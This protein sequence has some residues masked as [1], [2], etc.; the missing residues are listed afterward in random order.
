MSLFPIRVKSK[1]RPP[2]TQATVTQPCFGTCEDDLSYVFKFDTPQFPMVRATEYVCSSIA[3]AVGLPVPHW[4]I[5]EDLDGTHVFASQVFG[6]KS[7]TAR[8]VQ[9][10]LNFLSKGIPN[11]EM[12]SQISRIYAFDLFIANDDRHI[13]NLIFRDHDGEKVVLAID[14]SHSLFGKWPLERNLPGPSS[15]TVK[16]GRMIRSHWGFNVIEAK[17][18]LERIRGIPLTSISAILSEMPSGWLPQK[19]QND[20]LQWWGS[21][22]RDKWLNRLVK[23]HNDATVL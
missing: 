3:N 22:E 4:R 20:L 1:Y 8:T 6:D 12:L 10:L 9:D 5:A 21:L 15:N 13:N 23:G 14:F 19:E 2:Q 7:N 18:C 16:V 11:P 17:E